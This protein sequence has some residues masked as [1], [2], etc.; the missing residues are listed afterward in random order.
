M[1]AKYKIMEYGKPD[2]EWNEENENSFV[3]AGFNSI[4]IGRLRIQ[5]TEEERRNVERIWRMIDSG[6][7]PNG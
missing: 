7:L 1:M 4:S 6:E 5:M 3:V 2:P